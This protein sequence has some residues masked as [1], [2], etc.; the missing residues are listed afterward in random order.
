MIGAEAEDAEIQLD[1]SNN[2]VI[3]KNCAPFIDCISK[4][5]N[6]QTDIT[7]D[8]VVVMQM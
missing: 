2:G 4:I 8:L 3:F 6:T 7:K 1:K 5:S